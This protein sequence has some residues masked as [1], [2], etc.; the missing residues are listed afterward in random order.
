[1]KH[2]ITLMGTDT[3]KNLTSLILMTQVG[4]EKPH[5]LLITGMIRGKMCELLGENDKGR[6]PEEYFTVGLFSILDALM[7]MN[8]PDVVESLPLT[9]EMK[10]ALIDH[11]GPL[12][13]TLG[14]V[15]DHQAGQCEGMPI[16]LSDRAY[17]CQNAYIDAIKWSDE[18][19]RTMFQ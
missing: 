16:T 10:S 1:M 4:N 9:D 8:L 7:D 13:E 15:L 3:V 11:S 18:S 12:G 14:H 17:A 5:E 2:A 6:S 19:W